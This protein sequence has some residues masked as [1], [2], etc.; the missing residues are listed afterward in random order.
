MTLR[1]F[2]LADDIGPCQWCFLSGHSTFDHE[3][4]VYREVGPGLARRVLEITA[5]LDQQ[6]AIEQARPRFGWGYGV[7]D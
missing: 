2:R 4:R 6:F 1:P 5:F 3:M 7:T